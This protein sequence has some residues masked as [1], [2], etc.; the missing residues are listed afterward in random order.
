MSIRFEIERTDIG[1]FMEKGVMVCLPTC[2]CFVGLIKPVAHKSR[3]DDWGFA[4]LVESVAESRR[5]IYILRAD[6]NISPPQN[7]LPDKT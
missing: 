5:I 6:I 2:A 3:E 1:R 4:R 7:H